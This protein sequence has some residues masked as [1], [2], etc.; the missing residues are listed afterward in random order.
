MFTPRDL[1]RDRIVIGRIRNTSNRTLRPEAATFHVRDLQGHCFQQPSAEPLRELVRLGRLVI[2]NPGDAIA[3][4]AA[5]RLPIGARGAAS[6]NYGYGRLTIPPGTR[7][8]A[9]ERQPRRRALLPPAAS[10]GSVCWLCASSA[11]VDARA[12]LASRTGSCAAA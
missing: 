1:P 8:T 7:A 5:W 2:L 4:F 6:L 3:V 10:A 11:L 12:R 9:H